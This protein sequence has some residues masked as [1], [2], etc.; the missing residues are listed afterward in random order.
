ML[1]ELRKC[2]FLKEMSIVLNINLKE[3]SM[4]NQRIAEKRKKPKRTG[5]SSTGAKDSGV[6]IEKKKDSSVKKKK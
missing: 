2:R 5:T 1:L 4:S 6:V 3:D